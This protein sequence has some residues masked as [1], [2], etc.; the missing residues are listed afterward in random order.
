MTA[1]W[2][3]TT[4]PLENRYHVFE[5]LSASVFSLLQA[6]PYTLMMEN[7]SYFETSVPAYQT[8]QHNVKEIHNLKNHWLHTLSLHSV[9][10]Q[11]RSE[12]AQ[13]SLEYE[14]FRAG[15]VGG[16]Q[17]DT[18]RIKIRFQEGQTSYLFFST[19]YRPALRSAL[20]PVQWVGL[21]VV[22]FIGA[23]RP[24]REAN[25]SPQFSD[26]VNTTKELWGFQYSVT[27]HKTGSF[28]NREALHSPQYFTTTYLTL[29]LP[30]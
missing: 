18:R 10:L 6:H 26:E 27:S 28:M 20:P 23:Q 16:I 1:L 2:D 9:W 3:V 19:T 25:H 17:M 22:L 11:H 5:G 24:R 8:K 29:R 30:D 12:R 15:I 4:C 7:T 14:K 13:I 21:M